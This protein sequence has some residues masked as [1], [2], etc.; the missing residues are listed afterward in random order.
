MYLKV[1]TFSKAQL[2]WWLSLYKIG[3]TGP[4]TPKKKIQ[5]RLDTLQTTEFPVPCPTIYSVTQIAQNI[6]TWSEKHSKTNLT[7]LV[8]YLRSIYNNK[9]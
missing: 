8:W 1:M 2:H 9:N 4:P 3:L 6:T 5:I 7:C